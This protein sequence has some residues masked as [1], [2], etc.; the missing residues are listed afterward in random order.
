MDLDPV[1]LGRTRGAEV[2]PFLASLA[3]RLSRTGDF[4]LPRHR[5][6]EGAGV[7]CGR[8]AHKPDLHADPCADPAADVIAHFV[9]LCRPFHGKVQEDESRH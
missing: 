8:G 2:L 4:Q 6:S 5:T 1:P 3:I 7:R 9:R